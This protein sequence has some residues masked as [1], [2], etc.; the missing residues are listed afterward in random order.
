M[1]FIASGAVCLVKTVKNMFFFALSSIPQPWSDTV[2]HRLFFGFRTAGGSPAPS[3]ADSRTEPF[4]GGIS[5]GIVQKDGQDFAP[6][7]SHPR[8]SWA[9]R[10]GEVLNAV[11]RPCPDK[12]GSNRSYIS[13]RRVSMSRGRHADDPVSCICRCQKQHIAN[14][15]GHPAA[16][17][18]HIIHELFT[19]PGH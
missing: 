4:F 1:L 17:L 18:I 13:M 19:V 14:Q 16:F 2:R 9:G 8:L 5:Q 7:A 11:P 15:I 12:G 10:I 6:G 3:Q